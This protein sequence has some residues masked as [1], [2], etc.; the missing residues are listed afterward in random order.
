MFASS[1]RSRHRRRN[2]TFLLVAA[3]VFLVLDII[4]F[5]FVLWRLPNETAW[6]SE[7][8][9]SFEY[10]LLALERS[11][12]RPAGDGVTRVLVAGSSIAAYGVL[13]DILAR[14]LE[15]PSDTGTM[16]GAAVRANRSFDVALLGRQGLHWVELRVL[17][18]RL[19]ALRP[20]VLIVPT[21]MVDFRLERA[22]ALF[23]R[24]DLLSADANR[25][26]EAL[27]VL[28]RD[29]YSRQ[30]VRLH[31]PMAALACCFFRMSGDQRADTIMSTMSAAFRFRAVW[32]KPLRM[33]YRNRFARGHSYLHYAGASVGSG[34]VTHR[35][36]TGA[37]FLLSVSAQL[38]AAGLEFEAPPQLFARAE[39][40]FLRLRVWSEKAHRSAP[41]GRSPSCPTSSPRAALSVRL[42]RGWQNVPLRQLVRKGDVLCGSIS[43]SW[44]SE[45]DADFLG[46]RLARN[47]GTGPRTGQDAH[48]PLRREDERY[49]DY[50][51][52]AYRSSFSERIMR[53][54]RPGAEYLH[55]LHRTRL[56]L[57]EQAFDEALPSA[58]ALAEFRREVTGSGIRLLLVNAPENPLSRKLYADSRWYRE[59]TAFLK[60]P[61][62]GAPGRFAFLD[63]GD[64]LEMQMFYDTHHLSY[65]GAERFSRHLARHIPGGWPGARPPIGT[66]AP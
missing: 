50:S 45:L 9:Y 3:C 35:G 31:A 11:W 10:R 65:Y 53:F 36:R 47:T 14:E 30:E 6:E 12:R 59:Y 40:V 25:R 32:R 44:W 13:P 46:L 29:E 17:A 15:R 41:A 52:E 51:D 38:M 37:E 20:D 27:A 64:L 56:F 16:R 43:R 34:N 18:R 66:V 57:R 19:A 22:L 8:L 24:D 33:L 62:E 26:A 61:P 7:P 60:R 55:A 1:T 63:A 4:L 54:S 23:R 28:G 39:P 5:R 21:N 42:R 49:R 2:A 58:Q 48:R